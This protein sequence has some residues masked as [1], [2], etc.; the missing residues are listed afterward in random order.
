MDKL[1]HSEGLLYCAQQITQLHVRLEGINV[2]TQHFKNAGQLIQT[3][4]PR[5]NYYYNRSIEIIK[6]SLIQFAENDLQ[7]RTCTTY[8]S[9]VSDLNGPLQSHIATT[10]GITNSSIL[11]SSRYFHVVDGLV[12][13]IMHD[14]LEGTMQVT[15]KCLLYYLIEENHMF[16]LTNLNER[17]SSFDYGHADVQNRPSEISR[18]TFNSSSDALKQSGMCFCCSISIQ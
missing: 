15:L 13:D 14:I 9:H 4:R 16:T 12:P 10:Y 18:S 11:N 8:Q 6:F 1:W 5:Y 2:C 17:I 3:C 7:L